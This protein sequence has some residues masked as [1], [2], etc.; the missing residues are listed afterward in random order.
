[1][2]LKMGIYPKEIAT[3]PL[4][5]NFFKKTM[6]QIFLQKPYRKLTWPQIRE[7]LSKS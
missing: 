4:S 7:S 2:I 5:L 3:S 6:A 1:M